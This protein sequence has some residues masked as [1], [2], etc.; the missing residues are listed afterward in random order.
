MNEINEYDLEQS[1]DQ[2]SFGANSLGNGIEQ[3]TSSIVENSNEFDH[4]QNSNK[5]SQPQS[6]SR[7]IL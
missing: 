4:I 6:S 5:I 1:P 7:A 3:N 2:M